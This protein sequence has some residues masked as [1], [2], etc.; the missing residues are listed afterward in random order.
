MCFEKCHPIPQ[1]M[2]HS[3]Y[4]LA[5]R[6]SSTCPRDNSFF[7]DPLPSDILTSLLP[8][9][10][11]ESWTPAPRSIRDE[12]LLLVGYWMSL[13]KE[14]GFFQWLCLQENAKLTLPLW[15]L[16]F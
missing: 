6:L 3:E 11:L 2:T 1:A 5:C 16:A 4:R 9:T 15:T 14:M 8:W 10:P 12:V 7:L 13:P